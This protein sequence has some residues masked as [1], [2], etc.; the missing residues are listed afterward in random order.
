MAVYITKRDR[1]EKAVESLIRVFMP[2]IRSGVI[3]DVHV[4]LPK[5]RRL[6]RFT[7]PCEIKVLYRDSRATKD[8]E[9]FY[10]KFMTEL[11]DAGFGWN[12][13]NLSLELIEPGENNI[14]PGSISIKALAAEYEKFIKK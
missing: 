2:R 13:V 10:N 9:W 8:T 5:W 3:S 4:Y 11:G 7:W 14:G 1:D 12:D 6:R